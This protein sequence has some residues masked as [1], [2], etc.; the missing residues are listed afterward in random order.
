MLFK[1]SRESFHPAYEESSTHG[2]KICSLIVLAFPEAQHREIDQHNGSSK[3]FAIQNI[4]P[5]VAIPNQFQMDD[6]ETVAT[7]TAAQ[8]MPR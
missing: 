2:S 4:K 1:S 7:S 6:L 3:M 5:R 8:H